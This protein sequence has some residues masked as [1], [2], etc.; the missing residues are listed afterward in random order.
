MEI[1]KLF[2]WRIGHLQIEDGKN[3]K[4]LRKK[5]NMQKCY[6]GRS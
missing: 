3:N 1:G 4:L 6:C 5:E 2:V